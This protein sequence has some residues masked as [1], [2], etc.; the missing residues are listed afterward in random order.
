MGLRLCLGLAGR[1]HSCTVGLQL[2]QL[3]ASLL[4]LCFV[5]DLLPFQSSFGLLL[6]TL[7]L[8]PAR[9]EPLLS[10]QPATGVGGPH[11]AVASCELVVISMASCTDFCS[12]SLV[13]WSTGSTDWMSM[14]VTTRLLDGN[15]NL[16]RTFPFSSKPN[17]EARMILAEF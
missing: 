14:L 6:Q 1:L 7:C 12:A 11:L 2:E 10:S 16:L 15:T 5:S 3:F 17:T 9:G 4:R 8:V 13:R